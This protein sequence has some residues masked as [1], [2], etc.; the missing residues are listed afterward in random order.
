MPIYEFMIGKVIQLH[1]DF[2]S[3]L[4]FLFLDK[5][6]FFIA[7][8]FW[9]LGD[10]WLSRRSS[11][12]KG[13][14]ATKVYTQQSESFSLSLYVYYHISVIS[15]IL[16]QD[17]DIQA[18]MCAVVQFFYNYYGDADISVDICVIHSPNETTTQHFITQFLNSVYN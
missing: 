2:P 12:M 3:P 4:S 9:L 13:K 7:V 5:I 18:F 6:L 14:R 16:C 15:S 1:C 10:K 17:I 11:A 8:V